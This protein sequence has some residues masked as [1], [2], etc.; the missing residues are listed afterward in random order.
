ML[1]RGIY[2]L[3]STLLRRN[4][5]A[6]H[7]AG[8]PF[9]A[10]APRML[11]VPKFRFASD[12][13]AH[14]VLKVIA[15]LSQMPALSPTMD[16]GKILKWY[17]KAGDQFEA[18]DVLCDVETDKTTVPFEMLDKGFI[19]KILVNDNESVKVGEPVVVIVTKKD[20]VAAFENFKAGGSEPA[21]KKPKEA[22]KPAKEE[23]PKKPATEETKPAKK[24]AEEAPE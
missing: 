21:S 5:F 2:L 12:L 11:T 13:P 23:A 8:K 17:K 9:L 1:R 15:I 16:K 14:E 4:L 24:K 3:G 20:A 19:A 22:D 6:F 7:L 10:Q 18:G